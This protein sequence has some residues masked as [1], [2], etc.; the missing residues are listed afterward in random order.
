M[1]TPSKRT[2]GLTLLVTCW[3]ITMVYLFWYFMFKDL[4]AFGEGADAE[5]LAQFSADI[6][7]QVADNLPAADVPVT[8]E[9]LVILWDEG[10]P[11][12]RFSIK[13]IK[14]IIAEYAP[15]GIRFVVAVPRE[16][17]K[18]DALNTFPGVAEAMVVNT[19]NG[20]SSPSAI[21]TDETHDLIYSGPF[22]DGA[23]CTADN[24]SPVDIILEDMIAKESVVPWLNISSFGCYCDWPSI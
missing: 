15:E 12:S 21:I 24:D 22:S 6:A 7:Q 11:C 1:Q 19:I 16:N 3:A 23:L 10:C 9:H 14:D 18:A 8:Q 5:T 4:R 20:I 13:H 17:E 2:L